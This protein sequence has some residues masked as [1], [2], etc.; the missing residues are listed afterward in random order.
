MRAWE[1]MILIDS[2]EFDLI[3]SDSRL[4][5]PSFVVPTYLRPVIYVQSDFHLQ[6]L[7]VSYIYSSFINIYQY[8]HLYIEEIGCLDKVSLVYIL[9]RGPTL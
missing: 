5:H 7:F 6:I 8:N 2:L 1:F 4:C 3:N 9:D